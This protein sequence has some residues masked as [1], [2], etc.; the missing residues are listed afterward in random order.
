MVRCLTSARCLTRRSGSG[1]SE[2][3]GDGLVTDD[4]FLVLGLPARAGLADED[5]RA[6]WRRIA[7]ATHPDREDGGDP[8][9]FGAAAAAY[10]ML[11]TPFGRGEAL[12]D[13]AGRALADPRPSLARHSRG[14]RRHGGAKRRQPAS[15]ARYFGNVRHVAAG[16]GLAFQLAGAATVAVLAVTVAGW[17]P[18]GIGLLV[19]AATWLLA[20]LAT[21][22]GRWRRGGWDR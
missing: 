2:L 1:M 10:A 3:P 8:A 21:G 5:V 6:A 22:W 13:L 11:R 17:S 15:L 19:G 20:Q 4:P 18:A 16:P 7:A 12:V 9:W 14:S